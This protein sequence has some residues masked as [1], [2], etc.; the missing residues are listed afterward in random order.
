MLSQPPPPPEL[1]HPC[2][3]RDKG[4]Q[5][6]DIGIGLLGKEW[7]SHTPSQ[8]GSLLCLCMPGSDRVRLTQ[9]I[10]NGDYED[11]AQGPTSP[12]IAARHRQKARKGMWVP[13]E[14]L[15]WLIQVRDLQVYLLA[16]SRAS[17]AWRLQFVGC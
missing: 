6:D 14:R 15:S 11:Q 16:S 7:P 5:R 17:S 1:R 2:G 12:S 3:C 8:A 4:T 13:A 9:T 10:C